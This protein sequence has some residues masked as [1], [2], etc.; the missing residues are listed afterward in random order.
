MA[1]FNKTLFTAQH[2]YAIPF[3]GRQHVKQNPTNSKLA[4]TTVHKELHT[5]FK[6][7]HRVHSWDKIQN[8]I[9]FITIFFYEC[10]ALGIR[11]SCIKSSTC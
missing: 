7:F 9:K 6:S 4:F 1:S 2:S 3:L 10:E 11:M 8:G 5:N